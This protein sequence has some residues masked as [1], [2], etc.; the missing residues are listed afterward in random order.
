[1]NRPA[2]RGAVAVETAA[3]IPV[4]V[5]VVA[6]AAMGWRLWWARAQLTSATESAARY[7]AAAGWTAHTQRQATQLIVDDL[8]TVGLYCTNLQ[9]GVGVFASSDKPMITATSRCQM[10]LSDLLIPGIPGSLQITAQ[11]SQIRDTFR[12]DP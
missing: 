4:L 12:E 7:V 6:V 5:L 3:L 11:S 8:D 10:N 2:S 9:A 1:M